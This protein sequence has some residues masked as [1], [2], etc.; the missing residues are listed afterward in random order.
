MDR[1]MGRISIGGK[2]GDTVRVLVG[3][4][5]RVRI[6]KIDMVG[7]VFPNDRN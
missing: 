6:E 5:V 7:R 2:G 1:S 4:G 3:V